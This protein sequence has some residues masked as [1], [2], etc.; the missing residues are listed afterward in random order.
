MIERAKS[1]GLFDEEEAKRGVVRMR[2][3]L[4]DEETME[5]VD[6]EGNVVAGEVMRLEEKKDDAFG[7]IGQ[8]ILAGMPMETILQTLGFTEEKKKEAMPS[9][10]MASTK[11]SPA[12]GISVHTIPL[13]TQAPKQLL[14]ELKHVF[15][16]FPGREKIQLKIGEQLVPLPLTITMSPI[17]EKKIEEVI[18]KF[19]GETVGRSLRLHRKSP[20]LLTA[21]IEGGQ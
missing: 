7:P 6:E 8:W 1:E 10:K 5:L 17:L 2:T 18:A 9:K 21:P 11:S 3:D 14:L 13:P 19:S 16:T 20:S 12:A 4:D 15:E